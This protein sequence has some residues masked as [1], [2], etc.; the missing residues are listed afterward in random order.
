MEIKDIPFSQSAIARAA[1][2][3]E[4]EFYNVNMRGQSGCCE[5][6]LKLL[7]ENGERKIIVLCDRGTRVEHRE[8]K[9]KDFFSRDE[10]DFEICRL[11][12]EEHLTQVFLANLFKLTQPSVSLFK[13]S[14]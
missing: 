14:G 2:G 5:L 12:K 9:L 11:Y 7:K 3:D 4:I 8:V 13:K 10:R 1:G 6:E